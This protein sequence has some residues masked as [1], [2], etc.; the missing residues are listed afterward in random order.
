MRIDSEF[1]KAIFFDW[2]GVLIEHPTN[3]ILNYCAVFLGISKERLIKVYQKYHIRL[4]TG[5]ADEKDLWEDILRSEGKTINLKES[6]W[7]EAFSTAYSPREN[8][9][10]L[11]KRLRNNGYKI[12]L[13]S[14]TESSAAELFLEKHKNEFDSTV[15]SCDLGIIKPYARIYYKALESLDVLAEKSV[16]IDDL[17]ENIKGAENIGM[18][19]ILYKSYEQVRDELRG[20]G[21]KMDS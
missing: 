15:F 12:G 4:Q 11:V 8:M 16:F 6:L 10:K 5:E 21:A 3:N 2:G 14:N 18:K 7:R 1:I 19:G 13:I 9:F 20:F 17:E